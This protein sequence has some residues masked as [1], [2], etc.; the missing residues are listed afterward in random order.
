MTGVACP[1]FG[2]GLLSSACED[3]RLRGTNWGRRMI[4]GGV[5]TRKRSGVSA[6]TYAGACCLVVEENGVETAR[7]ENVAGVGVSGW[8]GSATERKE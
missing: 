2:F 4:R 1:V 3:H 7:E 5:E 8:W 6:K